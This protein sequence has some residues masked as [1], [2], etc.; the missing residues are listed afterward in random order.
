M[1]IKSSDILVAVL[2]IGIILL[3][4]IPLSTAVLDVLLIL[5]LSISVLVLLMSLYIKETLEFSTFPTLLLLLTLFRLALNISATRLILGNSGEAGNV[6][7]TFATFVMGSNI[8][9]GVII[10]IIIV[11]VQ[12]MVITKGSERVAE[13]AARFTLD[14]MPGKQMAIDADLNTGI[15]NEAE[16]KK[17]REDVQREA[18]FYG[19]MDGAS[20]FIKGDS[21]V[22]IIITVVNIV[23]GIVIGALG[24]GGKTM[25][26][27]EVMTVYMNASVGQGLVSQIPALFGLHVRGYHRHALRE[28]LELRVRAF[29]G[30]SSPN[31]RRFTF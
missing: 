21:I 30:S 17:R 5:N 14:A 31:H 23:G 6:I 11:I 1:K 24:L 8:A 10:F 3:I 16:A 20:K 18:D 13:V 9:V 4:I 28:F 25:A 27:S 22:G 2:V 29:G 19:A 7:Q 12:F 15:I 26:I